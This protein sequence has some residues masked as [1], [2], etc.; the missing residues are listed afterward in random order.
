MKWR[1]SAMTAPRSTG[2]IINYLRY[3][4][5]SLRGTLFIIGTLSLMAY[6]SLALGSG[7]LGSVANMRFEGP[8]D[9]ISIQEFNSRA[10]IYDLFG[11]VLF[12]LGVITSALLFI[13][14][15]YTAVRSFRYL[16]DRKMTDTA[17]SL[18]ISHDRRF[19]CGLAAGA[20]VY[21][22]PQLIA[23]GLMMV[24]LAVS[25]PVI[26]VGYSYYSS[27]AEGIRQ[28][29]LEKAVFIV[30]GNV[31]MYFFS[32]MMIS[33]CG[34]KLTAVTVPFLY[35]G[36]V[37][38][39][40]VFIMIT[41]RICAYGI[42]A[43]ERNARYGIAYG[44]ELTP[45]GFILNTI[46]SSDIG[47]GQYVIKALV[48]IVIYI[49]ASYFLVKHR[50]AERTGSAFVYKGARWLT[51]FTIIVTAA[52]L[53]VMRNYPE[54]S[55][56]SFAYSPLT[57]YF[58]RM[59]IPMLSF[60]IIVFSAVIYF[61]IEKISRER[62]KDPR[63]LGLSVF[64]F[65]CSWA[66]ASAVCFCFSQSGWLLGVD[67][68]PEISEVESIGYTD[69]YISWVT[70]ISQGSVTSAEDIQQI[71]NFHRTILEKRPDFRRTS[72]RYSNWVDSGCSVVD[73]IYYL[74]NGE[75]LE[76][77]YYLPEE[78]FTAAAELVFSTDV[79]ANGY[80][81]P[82]NYSEKNYGIY[83][84]SYDR[85]TDIGSSVRTDIPIDEFI[86]TIKRDARNTTYDDIFR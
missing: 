61:I 85:N 72:Q 37:T 4:L 78:Y 21:I 8:T 6:P 16:I 30:V 81:L 84:Y 82:E 73:I 80:E 48:C 42:P 13:F 76:S 53:V 67:R 86:E 64:R 1:D 38:L 19:S 52:A 5:T 3:R 29:L 34:R 74:K 46:T 15:V 63:R 25:G 83:Y 57:Y 68:I 2:D 45:L 28:F 39:I 79:F 59:P 47:G 66:L 65:I 33:V 50:R 9:G 10:T 70:G 14:A 24:I 58:M 12:I 44:A 11:H 55:G 26:H 49:I 77:E 62:L 20:L 43:E 35:T 71:E 54:Y 27:E 22:I 40:L 18:P 51:Q 41:M 60:V 32:V 7:M 56:E 23:F 36:L 75:V 31:M 69:H 17:M